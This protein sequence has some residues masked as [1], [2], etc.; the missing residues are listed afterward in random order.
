MRIK[1]LI[2]VLLFTIQLSAQEVITFK[3]SEPSFYNRYKSMISEA[4]KQNIE[5]YWIVY[6][7]ERLMPENSYI[8]HFSRS[9]M[10]KVKLAEIL[11]PGQPV[12]YLN[13]IS[14]NDRASNKKVLKEIAVLL[15]MHNHK[16]VEIDISTI[17]MHVDLH[18]MSVML[19][20][21]AEEKTS[22]EF[23]ADFYKDALTRDMKESLITAAGMHKSINESFDFLLD[24]IE[25]EK[26]SDLREEA[27]FW[28]GNLENPK[29]L[30]ILKNI[31]LNEANEDVAEKAVFAL[32]EMDTEE[33]VEALIEIAK[34]PG[35]HDIREKAIFWLGELAGERAINTLDE[36]I[37]SNEE[38]E[39]QEQA[40]FALAELDNGQ[41]IPKL[42]KVANEHPNKEVR[43][44]AIFWLGESGDERALQALIDMVKK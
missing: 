7:F 38:T 14:K 36:I 41:G 17:D 22:M 3:G 5:N 6:T 39:L 26:D 21:M 37:Y 10:E 12:N 23:I 32:Y 8:G 24:K 16:V 27:V 11:Y 4:K 13:S 15:E 40:I 30:P 25:N 18:G 43:K 31:A 28:L 9:N 1:T 2:I 35:R 20:G 34:T 29:A 42:I 44:K 33:S 19:M